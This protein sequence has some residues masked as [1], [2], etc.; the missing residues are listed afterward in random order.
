MKQATDG[1][2]EILECIDRLFWETITRRT[3]IRQVGIKLSGIK[4]PSVQTDLFDPQRIRRHT[5]DRVVD[6]IRSRFGF[7]AVKVCP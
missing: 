6:Q 4:R 2:S 7:E 1:T 3:K 5:K